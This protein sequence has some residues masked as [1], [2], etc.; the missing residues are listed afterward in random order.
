M[1]ARAVRSRAALRARP[2]SRAASPEA[3]LARS[4]N[5]LYLSIQAVK[6]KHKLERLGIALY[7]SETRMQWS[8]NGDAFF[9][10]ASTMKL[11]VLVGVFRQVFRK[12]LEL[13]APVHVRNRFSSLIEDEAFSLDLDREASPEVAGRLGKTMSVKDL[14]YQMITTSSNLA[15]NLLIDLVTIGVI[16]K[17]LDE[18]RVQGIEVLRG[19]DDEKAFAAGKNNMV[20]AHGL[21]RLLRLISDGRVYSPEISAELLE[22]LLDQRHKSGI[23]AGLPGGAHV[24]HKTG[25]IS[26]VHHDAGIVYIGKRRPYA[27]VILTQSAAGVGSNTA[28]AEVSRQIYSALASLSQSELDRREPG[29][30]AG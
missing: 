1:R 23:P 17:A 19:V 11:A 12:E 30:Q 8:Y 18:L 6:R 27:A 13:G 10:A 29:S 28:V 21:L 15:T 20:T 25:N 5:S 16:Q 4:E 26:T 14:A 22:I 7:D 3:S 2:G 9:H 24:A